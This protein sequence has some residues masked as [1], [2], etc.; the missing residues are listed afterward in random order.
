[1]AHKQLRLDY[2]ILKQPCLLPYISK[3]VTGRRNVVKRIIHLLAGINEQ[4]IKVKQC[5]F[6]LGLSYLIV[7]PKLSAVENWLNKLTYSI[8]QLL[9]EINNDTAVIGKSH[10]AAKRQRGIE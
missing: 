10:C 4:L 9:T 1:M 6:P 3:A 2:R 7:C 5:N 8:Q